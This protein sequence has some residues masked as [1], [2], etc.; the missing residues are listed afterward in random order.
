M[1]KQTIKSGGTKLSK[2]PKLVN[3]SLPFWQSAN[4]DCKEK[5]FLMLGNSFLLHPMILGL[6]NSAYRVYSYMCLESGGERIF[7]FPYCKYKKIVSKPTFQRA[8]QEL[9]DNRLIETLQ[10]NANLRK[11]NVYCFNPKW[12]S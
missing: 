9:I 10:N 6:S 3:S 2:R 8:L 5:R 1:N 7:T 11:A 4:P 12:R